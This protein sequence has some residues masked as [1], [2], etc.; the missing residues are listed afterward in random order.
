MTDE[1]ILLLNG[2]GSGQALVDE[3]R[4]HLPSEDQRWY[5]IDRL[6]K[7][8]VDAYER[9][10]PTKR[11]VASN[12]DIDWDHINKLS[13]EWNELS[14]KILAAAMTRNCM[15]YSQEA[16]HGVLKGADYNGDELIALLGM[17]RTVT[18]DMVHTKLKS[19]GYNTNHPQYM[20]LMGLVRSSM[21]KL[22]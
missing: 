21:H 1:E 8:V 13:K 18:D 2:P 9:T 11:V 4:A 7:K 5:V 22:T 12:N 15:V 6:L 19:L 14:R 10:F 20:A 16:I 17:N 3:V